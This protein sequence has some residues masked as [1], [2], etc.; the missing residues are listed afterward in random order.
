MIAW[1]YSMNPAGSS[2]SR[3]DCSRFG[4]ALISR[5]EHALHDHWSVHQYQMPG[6][7]RQKKSLST[8]IGIRGRLHL[9]YRWKLYPSGRRVVPGD[10]QSVIVTGNYTVVATDPVMTDSVHGDPCN[11]RASPHAL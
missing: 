1:Q 4:V 5:G 2:G 11:P 10:A 6:L 3:R 8:K 9:S 7:A